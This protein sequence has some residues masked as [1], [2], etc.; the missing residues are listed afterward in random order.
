MYSTSSRPVRK[1]LKLGDKMSI[2]PGRT[3]LI[4]TL[5]SITMPTDRSLSGLVESKVSK[6]SRGLSH[7][8]TTVDADWKGN[9]LI[10]VHNHSSRRQVLECG[11][12]FCTLVLL[13]N[14]SPATDACG[15][16]TKRLD[17][18]LDLFEKHSRR[19]SWRRYAA[20]AVP[21]AVVGGS[22]AAGY[23]AFGNEPGLAAVVAGGVVLAQ[24]LRDL[25][26]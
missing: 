25:L 14:E 18:L 7:I 26:D 1:E 8:S 24:F 20:M 11:E 9:L 22:L 15:K 17:V 21:A 16:G 12:P 23:K 10:A 4:E 2:R 13:R 19:R 5:E 3:A 6:V